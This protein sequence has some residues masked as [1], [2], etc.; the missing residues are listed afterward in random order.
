MLT[1][2]VLHLNHFHKPLEIIPG[3]P[4]NDK[5]IVCNWESNNSFQ[6]LTDLLQ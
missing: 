3:H 1:P 6:Q 5:R 2:H 4:D